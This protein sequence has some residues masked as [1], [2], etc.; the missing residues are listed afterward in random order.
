MSTVLGPPTGIAAFCITNNPL[1]GTHGPLPLQVLL[2][3]THEWNSQLGHTVPCNLER[4]L[5]SIQTNNVP[6]TQQP[7]T[8]TSCQRQ[9]Q[10]IAWLPSEA[11]S[12]LAYSTAAT[13][14][15]RHETTRGNTV[16]G[17]AGQRRARLHNEHSQLSTDPK[18][19]VPNFQR[20]PNRFLACT[21]PSLCNSETARHQ[22][23][24]GR[25]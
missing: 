20:G 9:Y 4:T 15:L 11:S 16:T 23:Q 19:S 25:E 5:C 24:D 7:A 22:Q 14:Q 8:P 3:E 21:I 17:T 13:I 12:F 6:H 18:S 1:Q 10:Q 2:H